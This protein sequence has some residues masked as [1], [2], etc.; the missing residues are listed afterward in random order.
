M[1]LDRLFLL[2]GS[3]FTM[4]EPRATLLGDA[5]ASSAHL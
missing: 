3:G 5:G 4:G 2:S 1:Y